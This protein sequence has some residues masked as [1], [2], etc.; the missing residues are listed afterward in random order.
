MSEKTSLPLNHTEQFFRAEVYQALHVAHS[1]Y[2]LASTQGDSKRFKL[3]FPNCPIAQGYAQADAKV[4]YNLQFGIAPS[5]CNKQLIYDV[6]RHSFTFK[7]DESTNRPID[8]QYNEYVQYWSES[9]HKALNKYCCSLFL[10][11]CTSDDLVDHFK[12]FVV[13][14]ELDTNS[15]LHFSMDG[16]NVNLA[17]QEKLSKHLRDN[18]NKSFVNLGTCSLHSVHPAFHWGITSVSFDLDQVFMDSHFFFKLSNA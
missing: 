5:Y 14:N 12:Q 16:P 8:K 11:H 4:E 15:L 3:M 9:E 17:F 10:G 18:L 6:K 1:N 7:F 2:S 13:D